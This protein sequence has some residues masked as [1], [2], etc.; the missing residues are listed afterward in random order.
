M[1][2][3]APLDLQ[4][5]D[6]ALRVYEG[7]FPPCERRDFSLLQPLM[8]QRQEFSFCVICQQRENIGILSSWQFETFAYIEHFAILKELRTKGFG[9]DS[10][11]LFMRQ[12]TKPIIIEVEPAQT[13]QAK[14]RV[15]FYERLGF[16]LLNVQYKQPPY[17][18]GEE[19]VPMNIM[20]DN[21]KYFSDN[22]FQ[23]ARATLYSQVYGV[24]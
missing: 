22:N 1:I 2:Y 4:N 5:N 14:R 18:K 15:A 11:R 7:A 6:F 16:S 17:R 21:P 19:F 9:S 24:K 8:E 12:T 3:F 13:T 10:L 20:T 23:K